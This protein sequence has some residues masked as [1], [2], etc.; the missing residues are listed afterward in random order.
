MARLETSGGR[1]C[2]IVTLSCLNHAYSHTDEDR[3][4]STVHEFF[5][6]ALLTSL[7]LYGCTDNMDFDKLMDEVE[8]HPNMKYKVIQAQLPRYQR[9]NENEFWHKKLK[10]RGFKLIRK[11]GNSTGAEIYFYM[12]IPDGMKRKIEKG[13][14]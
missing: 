7:Q 2:G 9:W 6:R 1:N 3:I 14:R 12:R 5:N 10:A 8:A 11:M 13:D 4:F